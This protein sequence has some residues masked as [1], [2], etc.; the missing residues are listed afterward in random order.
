LALL[1]FA[2]AA[3]IAETAELVDVRVDAGVVVTLSNYTA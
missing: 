1:K 2:A 3:T